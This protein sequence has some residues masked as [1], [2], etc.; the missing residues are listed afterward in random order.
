MLS[1]IPVPVWNRDDITVRGLKLL[2]SYSIFFCE[3]TRN[4]QKL[5]RMY[6][7]DFRNKK[8]YSLNSFS[9]EKSME[10]YRGLLQEHNCW[11]VSDA[12]TPWLSDPWKDMIKMCWE[13][14]IEFEVLPGATA[15]IPAVVE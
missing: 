7:I 15:L 3:D 12:W 14:N 1:V 5:C 2:E 8:F 11:L 10:F 4:L 13:W 9:S 6:E